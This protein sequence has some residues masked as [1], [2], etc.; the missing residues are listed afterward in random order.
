M[1]LPVPESGW[2]PR[3]MLEGNS[4]PCLSAA[5][6]N[7][8]FH[9]SL[10]RQP[11]PLAAQP[12]LGSCHTCRQGYRLAPG[13]G[14]CGQ[15]RAQSTSVSLEGVA[16]SLAVSP[17]PPEVPPGGLLS[18]PGSVNEQVTFPCPT[19]RAGAVPSPHVPAAW[20]HSRLC[21][22]GQEPA[23]SCRA[24]SRCRVPGSL[25]PRSQPKSVPCLQLWVSRGHGFFSSEG[26]AGLLPVELD[27]GQAC[28]TCAAETES[29]FRLER[30]GA[31]IAPP[32]GVQSS[33]QP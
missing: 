6:A 7:A 31:G 2:V 25:E 30:Q 24:Q 10:G 9:R 21:T 5:A 27:R 29:G 3:E 15:R 13:Y 22:R 14:C 8:P 28:V 18:Y 32:A 19:S 12:H 4:S 16:E 11:P 1:V 20:R 26:R 33:L 17:A 23:T